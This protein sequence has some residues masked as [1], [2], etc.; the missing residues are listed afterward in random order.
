MIILEKDLFL[1]AKC[2]MSIANRPAQMGWT[3]KIIL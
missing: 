2:S 3:G 1:L